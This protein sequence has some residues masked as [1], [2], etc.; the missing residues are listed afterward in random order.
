MILFT[1]FVNNEQEVIGYDIFGVWQVNPDLAIELKPQAQPRPYQ[2]KSL[3]KMFGNG[4]LQNLL[5]AK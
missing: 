2:E 1:S 3:S 5:N 4:A